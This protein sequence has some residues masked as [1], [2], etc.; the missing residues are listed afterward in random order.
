[1]RNE[2]KKQELIALGAKHVLVQHAPAFKRELKEIAAGLKT[3][4]VY[5]GIGGGMIN[6]I[7]AS[8]PGRSTIYSYGFMGDAPL[9]EVYMRH[10]LFNSLAIKPFSVMGTE[11]VRDRRQLADALEVTEGY[12]GEPHFKT[13]VGELFGLAEIGEALEYAPGDNRKAVLLCD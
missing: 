13:K 7:I 4:A 10:F 12:I 3:T 9:S 11:T 2:E 5:D 6:Q 1:M 8:L